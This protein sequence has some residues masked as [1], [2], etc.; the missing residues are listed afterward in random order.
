MAGQLQFITSVNITS[1]QSSTT[2]DNVFTDEYKVYKIVTANF[3][4]AGTNVVDLDGRFID[5]SGSVISASEYLTS[6]LLWY[7]YQDSTEQRST[8]NT[9]IPRMF[10]RTN[11][12]TGLVSGSVNYVYSPTNTSS[13]T[14]VISQSSADSGDGIL[15]ARGFGCHSVEEA[16]RGFQIVETNGSR[17]YNNGIISVYGVK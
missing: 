15:G 12:T 3:T 17:P 8:S 2:V 1:S 11:G 10:G 9:K 7:N 14:F 5:N 13:N 4:L 16:I 6:H